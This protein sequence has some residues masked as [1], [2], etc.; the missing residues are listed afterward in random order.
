[1][2]NEANLIKILE[3][4]AEK[5]DGVASRSRKCYKAEFAQ[6]FHS[7]EILVDLGLAEWRERDEDPEKFS[8]R[9]TAKG[10]VYLKYYKDESVDPILKNYMRAGPNTL[11]VAETA[12]RIAASFASA[13]VAQ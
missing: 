1:M 10:Y 9:I 3:Q 7:T 4:M 13:V 11:E 12:I 6:D 8:A 5:N 2:I